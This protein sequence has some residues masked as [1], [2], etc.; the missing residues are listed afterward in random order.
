MNVDF[1]IKGIFKADPQKCYEELPDVVTPENVLEVAKNKDTELHKCFTWT[2][3]E[4]AHKWRLREARQL[5]QLFVVKTEKQEVYKPRIFQ[6]SSERNV[7]QEAT[8]FVQN[9]DEYLALINRAKAEL[10][11]IENRY[12]EITEMEEIFEAIDNFINE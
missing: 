2:D 3:S 4:A 11:A 7:Y 5:I 9:K 8:F 10:I 6:A 12:K 1:K